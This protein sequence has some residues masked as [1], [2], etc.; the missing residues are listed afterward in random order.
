VNAELRTLS[1]SQTKSG[2]FSQL[3]KKDGRFTL[4]GMAEFNK[5]RFVKTTSLTGSSTVPGIR[6]R[7]VFRTAAAS[8]SARRDFQEPPTRPSP[9]FSSR[10]MSPGLQVL[11]HWRGSSFRIRRSPA[12]VYENDGRDSLALEPEDAGAQEENPFSV[13]VAECFQ[14]ES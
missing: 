11:L 14:P 10:Y 3:L 13:I 7:V 5:T 6:W 1:N 4:D 2:V 8:G 12:P 9:R